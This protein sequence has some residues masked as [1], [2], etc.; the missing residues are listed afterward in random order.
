[1]LGE[2]FFMIFSLFFLHKSNINDNFEYQVQYQKGKINKSKSRVIYRPRFKLITDG[3][4]IM[5]QL[6]WQQAMMWRCMLTW[7][8]WLT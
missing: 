6:K 3:P 2:I 8:A 1:M 7:R 4:Q 5:C